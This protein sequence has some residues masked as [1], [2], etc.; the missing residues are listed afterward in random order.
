MRWRGVVWLAALLG[1]IAAY[2]AVIYAIGAST[3]SLL[4][5]IERH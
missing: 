2:A 5:A 4:T 3:A 1:T